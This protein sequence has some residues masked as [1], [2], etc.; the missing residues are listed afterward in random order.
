MRPLGSRTT[1]FPPSLPGS[2]PKSAVTVPPVPKLGSRSPLRAAA[3]VAAAR[4]AT[5]ATASML[6]HVL[7]GILGEGIRFAGRWVGGFAPAR[8]IGHTWPMSEPPQRRRAHTSARDLERYG[9]LFAQ[10]T[11]VMRS[12][13]M[14]DLMEITARPEVISLAGGL[15]DTSTFPP[16]SFAA[17]MT[18][19]AQESAAQALQYGPTEGFEA[20]KVAIRGVMATEGMAPDPEDVIVTTGGQQAID[21]LCKALIDP[22]D[23]VFCEAPTYPG[24]VPVF[25]SYEADV[26]QIE[27][28]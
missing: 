8:R 7:P 10:R 1:L 23:V 19:I 12:S 4:V 2:P 9:G 26:V 16:Q 3:G 15:P 14:R 25:C 21:L 11:K 28:D 17:Q 27:T 24:A 18:R 13:A 6:A 20:M 5:A 22:G